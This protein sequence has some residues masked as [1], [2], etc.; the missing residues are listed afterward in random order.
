[1]IFS[2]ESGFVMVPHAK[3]TWAPRGQTPCLLIGLKRGRW[4]VISALIVSLKQHRLNLHAMMTTDKV[5]TEAIIAFMAEVLRCESGPLL[6]FWDGAPI[7]DNVI[8]QNFVAQHPRLR[9]IYFPAYAPELNPCEGVW[10]QM[11]DRL[12]SKLMLNLDHLG[13]ELTRSLHI[14][15]ASQSLLWACIKASDLPWSLSH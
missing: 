5:A 10:A 9:L 1:M 13:R 7:H 8:V 6:W 2:D 11:V 3:R 12:S 14:T 15:R 4:N